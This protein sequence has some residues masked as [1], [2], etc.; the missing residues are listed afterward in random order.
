M[1]S[2]ARYIGLP[3]VVG[4]LW[5][6]VND[7][8]RIVAP[9]PATTSETL[10]EAI[11][12]EGPEAVYAFIHS[13]VDPN[14]PVAFRN[15]DMTGGREVTVAP[16]VLAVA[17]GNDNA[18]MTMLSFGANMELP[19]NRKAVC[20]ARRLDNGMEAMIVRDGRVSGPIDCP[21][22]SDTK[23]PLLDFVEDAF[24]RARRTYGDGPVPR[25]DWWGATASSRTNS[26]SGRG[27]PAACTIGFDTRR[28]PMAPGVAKG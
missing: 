24:E 15:D 26:S 19:S 25:P 14:V 28:T 20:L 5:I 12:N 17:R 23:F 22:A 11:R 1:P 7:V 10:A 16:I 3:A 4:A 9:S 18:V 6:C 2:I 21:P 13:G 27:A 8:A